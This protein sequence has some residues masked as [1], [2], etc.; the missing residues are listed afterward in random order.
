MQTS[1]DVLSKSLHRFETSRREFALLF[2]GL[3]HTERL[4]GCTAPLFHAGDG[5]AEPVVELTNRPA[6]ILQRLRRLLAQCPAPTASP[7]SSLSTKL[8]GA[9]GSPHRG[10]DF[11]D[12]FEPALASGTN[13]LLLVRVEA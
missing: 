12:I 8:F 10:I 4:L 6:F 3:Q 1:L 11:L 5:F 7:S 2:N 9:N 13:D